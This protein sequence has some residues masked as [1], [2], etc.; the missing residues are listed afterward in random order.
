MVLSINMPI[1]NEDSCVIC[2]QRFI[3]DEKS[4]NV[5]KK[6]LLTLISFSEKRG[7]LD[8]KNYLNERISA[9]PIA[10]VLVHA[11]CRRDFTDQKRLLYQSK[12]EEPSPKKLRSSLTTFSWNDNCIFC[13]QHAL[14][15]TRHPERVPQVCRVTIL[16]FRDTLMQCCEKRRDRWATEV[17]NRLH[18][19][20]D[21]VAAEAIYHSD[22]YSR[23]TLMKNLSGTEGKTKGRPEDQE[24]RH[25][26]EVLCNWLESEGDADLYSLSDL[27]TKMTEFSGESEVYTI[28]RLKQ[29]LQ[30]RYREFVFFAEVEG[31]SNVVCFRNMARYIINEQWYSEKKENAEEEASR[32]VTAA[33]K[34]IK[35]EIRERKYDL[36]SYPSNEDIANVEQSRNWIPHRLQTLLTHIVPSELKQNTI[37]HCIL[38]AARPRSVITP[39]LF[40]LGVELDHVF[41]SKWLNTELSRLGFSISYDEV[42]RYKQSVIQSETM[43][44]ILSEYF[45]GTF[46]QW[47]ADNLDHNVATL[48][49]QGTFH[50]MGI[51]AVS[52]PKDNRELQAKARVINRLQR[53]KPTEFLDEKGVPIFQYIH[54]PEKGLASIKFKPLLHL[55]TPYTLPPE[56]GCDLLWHSGGIFNHE[57]EPRPNWSGF[58]QYVFTDKDNPTPKSQ[59]LLLPVIDL[60]PSDESCIYSTLIYVQKQAERLAIPTPCIT[61]DQPLW[62]KATEII[63]AKS[64]NMV[65]RLGGFHTLMSFMGSIG[66]MMKGSGLEEALETTYGPNAVA[67]MMTGKAYSRALRGHFLVEAAL[68]N[69]LI[70]AV[71][72]QTDAIA[73]EM[74]ECEATS[75][76]DIQAETQVNEDEENMDMEIVGPEFEACAA[77][78][79]L[80]DE[81]VEQIR[82]LYEGVRKKRISVSEIA[83][84]VELKKMD[85]CLMKYKKRLNDTSPT[86]KLWLQYIE[87]IETMKL[88]IRAERT[89]DWNLHLVAV[90]KMLNIFAATGHINYAKSSRL[91][92]QEMLELPKEHPWLY[93]CFQ[94]NGCHVV[95]RT[96]RFWAGLW[97][98]LTIEQVMMRSVKSRGGLTRGRGVT[99]TV[100]LQWI[101]SMHKCAAVHEAMTSLTNA[102]HKTSEQHS[103][104]GESRSTRDY[105]DLNTVQTWFD[106]HEPFDTNETRLRSLSSGLTAS[107]G[108]GVNC[109]EVEKVGACIQRKL[110]DIKIPE[111][112]I[113]R[114]DQIKSLDSLYPGVQI[115][116]QKIRIDPNHLFQRLILVAQRENNMATFFEYEL[117]PIP[118]TLF[119]DCFMRKSQKSLLA[120]ALQ[121]GVQP[122]VVNA[123][124]KYVLDGGALLHRVKWKKKTTYKEIALQYVKYVRT[125]YGDCCIVFDGYDNGPS[126][127]DHE[128]K[129]RM[130]KCCADIQLS[131]SIKAHEDQQAFLSNEKNKS[132][133]ISLLTESL[134]ADE[135]EVHNSTGDAD[136]LIVECALKLSREGREVSVVADDTDILVLLMYHWKQDMADVYFHSE[137]SRTKQGLKVWKIR[138]IVTKAQKEVTS[139]ILFLHAWSGCDTTSATYGHGKSSLLKKITS[140]K[141]LRDLSLIVSNPDATAEE[142]GAAGIKTF[143]LLYGG[144]PS[145][146]LNN[147]RYS[148]YMQMVSTSK[149]TIEPQK[150]PPTERAAYYHALRVHLQITLWRQLSNNSLDATEWG[151]TVSGNQ[152]TPIFTDLGAA[153][154]DLLRFVR[155]KCKS[156][157]KNPCGSNSCSCRKHGLKC[158]AACGD[159]R[160]V[161][162]NNCDEITLEDDVE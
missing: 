93:K 65:C 148:K 80:N 44:N 146:T 110:D 132:Q 128:H 149:S 88:F 79:K 50:G 109:H 106:Q 144:K 112:S 87:Y 40:G 5:T 151:W 125:R 16:P 13:G 60:N 57:K 136:T 153:P 98:D 63:K 78:I 66:T 123:E 102:K 55:Q 82:K 117:T 118:T 113:K 147:L 142:V 26:F 18:G 138:D 92:I 107:E 6:G 159:C 68:V 101:Y 105:S 154:E 36:N 71:L 75:D 42:T 8:L 133:F 7:L 99:E 145:D 4:V 122:N 35:E 43:K 100:L 46:S 1:I 139:N 14:V 56:L 31:R 15:D 134:K 127:K 111:A 130:G 38:Q 51:I 29:K 121:D 91:Y 72:P 158:V 84:S 19:C 152:M 54:D 157:T 137:A 119:K 39:T 97:T 115:D 160:G 62:L 11:E 24:M 114:S 108:D 9:T 77:E 73:E 124:A 34:I 58:M 103:E 37:G 17:Q 74:E 141:D 41:G 20:I 53:M 131:E 69:K 30:D 96:S 104:L 12:T 61:F 116:K 85:Y 143:I 155:C 89:G 76:A 22:C 21:L 126:I 28:K 48:D 33:A 81:E 95:R 70:L 59:V 120:K 10:K 45:P 86:A 83:E 2:N 64:M 32:I 161:T 150:L 162:C 67:H 90:T 156:S 129:Q 52:T 3:G 94:E 25:W 47:V 23:F 135:Q 49:G 140:S 27:H